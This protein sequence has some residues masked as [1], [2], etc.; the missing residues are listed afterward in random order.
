MK[1]GILLAVYVVIAAALIGVGA[2][3]ANSISN[4]QANTS[5]QTN[6]SAA[7]ATNNNNNVPTPQPT[8]AGQSI[9]TMDGLI[10]KDDTIGM[11][12]VAAFGDAVTVNYTGKLDDGTVFDS[13]L[14]PGHTP[15]SFI[16]GDTTPGKGMIQ[17]WNEGV[18]GMKVGGTRELTIPPALGF[19]AGG[20]G[21]TIPPNATLHFTITLLA[22]STSSGQ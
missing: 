20:A 6:T 21:A 9:T 10:I 14:L 1:K 8:A 11:G 18:P 15:L 12:T 3:Y 13:S 22:V 2:W 19:G 5:S 7:A 17:G 4:S 16:I